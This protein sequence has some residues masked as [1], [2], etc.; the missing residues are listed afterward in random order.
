M[1]AMALVLLSRLLC[2]SGQLVV[3]AQAATNE[4][5]TGAEESPPRTSA[6]IQEQS[7]DPPFQGS[8]LRW[9]GW[10]LLLSDAAF[11]ALATQSNSSPALGYTAL[12]GIGLGAPALHLA[13]GNRTVAVVSLGARAATFALVRATAPANDTAQNCSTGKGPCLD[14]N[15]DQLEISTL[16]A[17]AAGL[18]FIIVDDTVLA[19]VTEPV[20]PPHDAPVARSVRSSWF[21]PSVRPT[22]GGAALAL[23]GVF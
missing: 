16:V 2:G 17:L 3:P 15:G 7:W 22:S 21:A 11:L 12:A 14:G 1:M 18:A 8:R 6:P 20:V 5:R 13:N 10:Q 9:Y 19:R 4:R 23:V